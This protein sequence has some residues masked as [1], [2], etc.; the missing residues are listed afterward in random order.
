MNPGRSWAILVFMNHAHP[1][2]R[3][4]LAAALLASI[5]PATAAQPARPAKWGKPM[6]LEGVPNLHQI[7]EG[8]YRGAQPT[9]EGMHALHKMGVKTIVNLRAFH[10][11]RDEIGSTPLAYVH[12]T[13]TPLHIEDEDVVRF[14]KTVQDKGRRPVFVH[15]QHGA[16]RTGVMC[17]AYRIAVQRWDKEDA[18]REMVHGGYGHHT[19]FGNLP[20]FLREADFERIRKAARLTAAKK[21][22]H[23]EGAEKAEGAQKEKKGKNR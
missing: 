20:K 1:L 5:L 15:C 17:A 2:P 13:M 10:S 23:A 21:R 11:D 16:D 22:A 4:I 14:L 7:G 19:I 18:I 6:K 9:R 12:I 3:R 8:V